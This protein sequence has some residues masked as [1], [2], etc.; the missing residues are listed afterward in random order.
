MA[1]SRN[2]KPG[3]FK[4]EQL[5]ELAFEDRIL[6]QGLWCEAD[7]EGRLEDRP[8]R[9]KA[10]VFPYDPVDVDAALS[11]LEKAGFVIRYVADG[12]KCIEVVNFGK[13]QNPHKKEAASA[14]PPRPAAITGQAPEIPVLALEVP[15][16]AVLI[17]DSLIPDSL[18][19][20]SKNKTG[21]ASAPT[22][23]EL[24][25]DV[26]P[27]HLRDW[28]TAR[29]AK[30]LP[31]TETAAKGF[32]NAAA[33]AGMTAAEA[34]KFC[35]EKGWAGLHADARPGPPARGSPPVTSPMG[36]QMQGVMALEERKRELQQRMAGNRDSDGPA[37]TLLL[38]AGSDAGR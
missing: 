14:L 35:A 37:E 11:R 2:I 33:K 9:I 32:R 6:F 3:F 15:A 30:R 21:A 18:I 23:A 7:R 13:H 24:F 8:R 38:V 19:P 26:D 25:P 27:G 4:N 12:R 5:A 36:K 28:L 1:R 10:E 29:R 16:S 34:V 22:P 17:P 20:E 31:L